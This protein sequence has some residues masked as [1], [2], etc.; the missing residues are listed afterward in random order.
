MDQKV[1]EGSKHL[2][3][4]QHEGNKR[5]KQLTALQNDHAHLKIVNETEYD[6]NRE[7]V[8]VKYLAFLF[9]HNVRVLEFKFNSLYYRQIYY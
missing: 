6:E 9:D 1:C 8:T 7:Q 5:E 4:L 3:A 2:N